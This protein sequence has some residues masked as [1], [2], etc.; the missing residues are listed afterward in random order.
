MNLS[1][2][3][4]LA[5]V[6]GFP[7]KHSLSPIIHHYWMEK[8]KIDG[9]YL[10]LGVAPEFLGVSLRRMAR[11]GFVGCN[12][13]V[14]H[15]EQAFQLVDEMDDVARRAQAVNMIAMR[16][17][18]YLK[19]YNTDVYGFM[20]CLNQKAPDWRRDLPAVVLGAGG[21]SRAVFVALQMAGVPE[22]RVLNRTR[23]RAEALIQNLGGRAMAMDWAEMAQAL[24]GAGLL[25]NATTLGMGDGPEAEISLEALPQT[26]VVYDIVYRTGYTQ[27][28]AEAAG[29]GNP[30]VGGLGMLLHQAA[31]SFETWF[32]VMPE[33]TAEL[34]EKLEKRL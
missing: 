5:A 4:R 7:A 1:A 13:T 33:V 23:G 22:I 29:R 16:E 27:L 25:V 24:A 6:V 14:P 2:S 9:A 26:A 20:A 17:D 28:L 34:E 8:Y 19:G 30:V 31:P 21:A 32:G 10:K 15:K 11:A 3:S 12:V 18:G